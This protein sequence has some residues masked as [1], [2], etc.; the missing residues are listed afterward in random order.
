MADQGPDER[1]ELYE[2]LLVHAHEL[3]VAARSAVPYAWHLDAQIEALLY[4]ISEAVG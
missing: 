4:E 1:V 2:V 3:L